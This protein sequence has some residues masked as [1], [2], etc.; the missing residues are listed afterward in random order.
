[1]TEP[2]DRD[3]LRCRTCGQCQAPGATAPREH[4]CE[5][6][7][8]KAADEQARAMEEAERIAEDLMAKE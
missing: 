5:C 4:D 8:D 6:A 3:S 2:Q 7:Q 1:M